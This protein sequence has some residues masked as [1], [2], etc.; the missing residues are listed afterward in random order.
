MSSISLYSS[1]INTQHVYILLKNIHLNFQICY[2][3]REQGKIE[4]RERERKKII[5]NK[6][7]KQT[8]TAGG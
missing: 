4:K 3:H 1:T 5:E 6:F 8:H 2:Y 7:G